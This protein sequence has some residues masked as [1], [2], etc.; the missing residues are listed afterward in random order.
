MYDTQV[1]KSNVDIVTKTSN[2]IDLEFNLGSIYHL[3]NI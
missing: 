1:N 3:D 2:F